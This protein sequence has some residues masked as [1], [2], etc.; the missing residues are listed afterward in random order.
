MTETIIVVAINLV[1]G[2]ASGIFIKITDKRAD[3]KSSIIKAFRKTYL[4]FGNI[5]A[6]GVPDSELEVGGIAD[7]NFQG[8]EKAAKE[9]QELHWQSILDITR[10][11]RIEWILSRAMS[12]IFLMAIVAI[13]SNV[14]GNFILTNEGNIKTVLRFYV[15]GILAFCEF[16]FVIWMANTGSYLT[17]VI[18]KYDYFEF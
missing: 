12:S 10:L 13:A 16:V 3:A 4:E 17:S 11:G 5:A 9:I 2:I 1:L 7:Y 15:P 14:I 6:A 8:V 18:N